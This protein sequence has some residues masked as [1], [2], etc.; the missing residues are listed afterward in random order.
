MLEGMEDSD[1]EE[2]WETVCE[3]KKIY[4]P[5]P[6]ESCEYSTGICTNKLVARSV[7]EYHGRTVHGTKNSKVLKREEVDKKFTKDALKKGGAGGEN[8]LRNEMN[9]GLPSD[10][11]AKKKMWTK[12]SEVQIY[13]QLLKE[14]GWKLQLLLVRLF[15][16]LQASRPLENTRGFKDV[17]ITFWKSFW[18]RKM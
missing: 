10:S 11:F 17:M 3:D 7:L 9:P 5:C 18:K 4:L 6:R 14:N 2:V 8:N 12:D 16:K 13:L 15:L 1:Y